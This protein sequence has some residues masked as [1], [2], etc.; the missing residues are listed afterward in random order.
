[1]ARPEHPNPLPGILLSPP[2]PVADGRLGG[3]ITTPR[4]PSALPERRVDLF[5]VE[6]RDAAFLRRRCPIRHGGAELDPELGTERAVPG[7]V[8]PALVVEAHPVTGLDSSSLA[9][10][11]NLRPMVRISGAA[12]SSQ[13]ASDVHAGAGHDRLNGA[14]K[15]QHP[16]LHEE[17]DRPAR[18]IG[19]QPV[20]D[21]RCRQIGE[22]GEGDVPPFLL[23]RFPE[24][25]D[26]PTG[27]AQRG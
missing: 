25:A 19:Q 15:R 18:I 24:H 26:H 20:H 7:R 16:Q 13:P 3:D 11:P 9:F 17:R 14:G 6:Q 4:G 1:V 2:A 23:R 8:R 10:W 22:D 21:L 27:P 5:E 12:P